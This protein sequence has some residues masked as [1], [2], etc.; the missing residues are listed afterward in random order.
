MERAAVAGKLDIIRCQG[1]WFLAVRFGYLFGIEW[2][3]IEHEMPPRSFFEKLGALFEETWVRIQPVLKTLGS[4]KAKE[5]MVME[6]QGTF[7]GYFEKHFYC[8]LC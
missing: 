2:G 8:P 7:L 1:V 5:Y 6:M 4:K 3:R